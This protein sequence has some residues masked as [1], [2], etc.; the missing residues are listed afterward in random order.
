MSTVK[1]KRTFVVSPSHSDRFEVIASSMVLNRDYYEFAD[2]TGIVAFV[3]ACVP[4]VE[5]DHLN[6]PTN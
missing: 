5:K 6:V 3:P 1:N 4:V 2:E